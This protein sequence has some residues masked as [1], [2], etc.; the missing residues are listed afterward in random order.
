MVTNKW[1]KAGYA[2]ELRSMLVDPA[3]AET[4]LVVDFGHARAFF[5]DA[6]VFPN[7]VVVR[8][9]DGAPAL[10][11][12]TVAVPS[13][14]NLSD[15]RLP[16]V[17]AAASFPLARAAFTREGWTLEPKPVMDLLVKIRRAGV[18]LTDTLG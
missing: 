9:P 15:A 18:P 8:R 11:T 12:L 14:D 7:V 16:E 4:E 17:V 1:L 13:R 6:D 2:E 10:D 3:R 5:P